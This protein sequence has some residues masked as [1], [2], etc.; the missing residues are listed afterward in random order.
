MV[1]ETSPL[2]SLTP[3]RRAAWGIFVA[4]ENT[5]EP[6][7]KDERQSLLRSPVFIPL[8]VATIGLLGNFAVNWV[9]NGTA[10]DLARK[11]F[12]YDLVVEATRTDDSKVAAKRLSFLLDLGYLDDPTGRI[13]FFVAHPDEL[14]L[15]PPGGTRSGPDKPP[16]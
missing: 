8:L 15:Q 11:K 9:Q 7:N 6:M 10:Q 14:P 16:R 3:Y 1:G 4:M 2:H 12:Q 5:L 13:R